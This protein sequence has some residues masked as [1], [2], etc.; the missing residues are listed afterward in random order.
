MET[1]SLIVE[2]LYAQLQTTSY[3]EYFAFLFGIAQV[4]LA[5]KNK[6]S[7]F[8]AG[9]VSVCLYMVL[10]FQSGLFAEGILNGYYLL[11]SII[12]VF[13]WQKVSS[14]DLSITKCNFKNWFH[15]TCIVFIAFIVVYF[16]LV[17]YTNSTVPF[18]DSLASA[19]AWAGSW[20]LIKRKIENWIFLNISNLIAIPLFYFKGLELTMLFTVLLFVVAIFGFLSWSKKIKVSSSCKI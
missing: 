7:N 8:Y 9:I 6:V 3:L 4:F 18:L 10:F 16:V 20:L 15:T 19:F 17:K 11:I 1:Q 12:G 13:A 2:H 5:L 14:A